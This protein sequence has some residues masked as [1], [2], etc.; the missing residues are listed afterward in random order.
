MV[1]PQKTHCFQDTDQFWRFLEKMVF[2]EA[3]ISKLRQPILMKLGPDISLHV[4]YDLCF[5]IPPK[6]AHR[7]Q[8]TGQ[9][10]RLLPFLDFRSQI[11]GKQELNWHVAF[12][13]KVG[14]HDGVLS[15][16]VSGK[17]NYSFGFFGKR[18]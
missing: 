5:M 8:V 13:K 15:Q 4:L 3:H 11:S 1:P 18:V 16:K 10:R 14:L 7:F 6:K 2:S 17:S 9:F 12:H